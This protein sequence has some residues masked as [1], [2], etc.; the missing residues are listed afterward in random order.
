MFK[1]Q[2]C[3]EPTHLGCHVEKAASFLQAFQSTIQNSNDARLSGELFNDFLVCSCVV[4]CFSN[5]FLC[6]H[7]WCVFLLFSRAFMCGVLFFKYFLVC[8][9]V[10]CFSVVFTC[11]HVWRVFSKNFLVCSMCGVLFFNF[12]HVCSC[13]VCV[14]H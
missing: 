13:V 7:V 3:H 2:N 9:C 5:F 10:V 11:V 12:F 6:V 8:S 4:C 1:E 14:F